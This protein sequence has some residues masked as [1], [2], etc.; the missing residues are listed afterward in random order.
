MGSILTAKELLLPDTPLLLFDCT[1]PDGS[2]QRWSSR[3]VEW[4]GNQYAGRV[5]RH[6]LF[7]AQLASDTQVGGVPQLTFELANADSLLSEVEQQSGF[8]GAQLVVQVAFFN[9]ILNAASTD[10]V[11]AFRGLMNP[12]ELI[13]ETTFR[14]SAM[15]RTSMQRTIIPNVR[16]QRMCPWRFPITPA[17]RLEA[18]DGGPLRGRYSR[19]YSCG[20]SPDQTNGT[21][22]LSAGSPFSTCSYSRSDCMDRGMFSI[23]TSGR[24]TARFGG[25]EY[26]PPTILVRGAGQ[27]NSQLSAVQDNTAQ[28][29][30]FVPLVYGTQWHVPDVV[31]SRN[32]GNL[33]RMEV[34]LSLGPI[35]GVLSVL[36]NDI[37]IPQGVNGRNMTST[38]WY[39]IVN[40]GSRNGAQDLNFTDGS[41]IPQGDPYGSMAYLSV[42]VPN[43]IND[44][45]SIPSIQVL[46]QGMKLPQYD[47]S[48][49]PLGVS[50]SSN[51]AWIVLDVL[52]RSGY[53]LSEIDLPSVAH[54]AAYADE[55]ISVLDPV[56]GSVELPRFQCQFAMKESR[57]A[58]DLLRS[59]RNGSRIYIVLNTSGLL[60]VRVENT[61]ALQQPVQAAGS[62]SVSDYNGGWPMYEFDASSI[63]RNSDGSSSVRLSSRGAQDTPNR[64]SVEFQD[65]FNQFQQDSLSIADEPDADLCGQEVAVTWDAVGISTFNQATRMLLLGLSKAIEG[66][67]TIQFETSVKALGLLPGDLITVTYLKENLQRTPFRITKITPGASFRSVVISAQLHDDGWYSDTI[68]GVSGGLGIQGGRGSGLP[69]PV[70]GTTVDTN[71]NLQLG[72][73][74]AEVIGSDG[75][76]EVDLTVSFTV[77]SGQTGTLP[78]PLLGLAPI[79]SP[80]GGTLAGDNTYFYGVTALDSEGGESPLSFMAQATVPAGVNTNSVVLDGIGLQ[81]VAAH[82]NVYRGTSA[83]QLFQIAAL[84]T[85]ATSFLDTGFPPLAILPPDPQFDHVNL[86]WRWELLPETGAGIHS[87]TTVG[88]SILQLQP[89]L[90]RTALVR[91]TRGAGAGQER[92]VA[93]NT[94]TVLTLENAW[95]VE[96]DATSYFVIAE[97][98][99]RPG[100]SGPTSPIDIDV[101]E[102]IGN[103]IEISARAANAA[104][105]EALYSLSPLTRWVLGQSGGLDA[106][107][108]VPPQ[109]LFGMSAPGRGVLL[110]AA[111]GF[112]S[113]VN[114]RSITAGTYTLHYYD[115]ISATAATLAAALLATDIEMPAI[116]GLTVGT[117]VQIEQEI[118]Q[119]TAVNSDGS[120]AISRGLHTTTAAA[121]VA[122]TALYPLTTQVVIVPFVKGV[123]GTPAGGEWS[124]SVSLPSVRLASAELYLTN[125]LGAGPVRQITYTTTPDFGLR[126]YSGG[127]FSFQITGYLAIQTGAAP[128]ISVDSDYS[129]RD[130]YAMLRS[131]AYGAAVTLQLNRNGAAYTAVS[132]TAGATSSDP[133]ATL[134]QVIDGFGLPALQASDQLSLD[135]TGVGTAI[136]GSDLTLIIRL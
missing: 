91:I 111:I 126:T 106:D 131:P 90:Y 123:F 64:L 48:G 105:D 89:N 99:W 60:E 37:E 35:Q 12:P 3:T 78:A 130:I 100:A 88:N 75:S 11:V 8:K 93:S 114:T 53:T 26:V 87:L 59:V 67:L 15:N 17:Q 116:A 54:A 30:D 74:E 85:P 112:P 43:Q 133:G 1:L 6:N 127:Q 79:V 96:P 38:G 55:L 51:P 119:V 34:L 68:S 83:G 61:F 125:A 40:D 92:A 52:M 50:F 107:A 57:S 108:A 7:E 135:V 69:A 41:G 82:F 118:L 110:L 39:N 128:N 58:G 9:L 101:P 70:I 18:V 76:A 104:G 117:F 47:S 134:S 27:K 115:E 28:Y 49:N 98:S 22:N 132:F 66:N 42:V 122:T 21:G 86:Y 103:G 113:L 4:N 81:A 16:V 5:V 56:G 25:I 84:Q 109:P 10:S 77:P 31:F 97:S 13:T 120:L 72:I 102:R 32:D 94:A 36:V 29:N 62:N 44:G 23:D 124:Y 24:P 14:L 2:L 33:T 73:S 65:S 121:H 19:F 129:V 136:P 71:G 63:A 20:Y 45:T 95:A 80:T 46:M